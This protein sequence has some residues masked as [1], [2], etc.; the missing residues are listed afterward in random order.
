MAIRCYVYTDQK[1]MVVFIGNY[2]FVFP[3]DRRLVYGRKEQ[4]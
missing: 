1:R 2:G 4:R 3:E